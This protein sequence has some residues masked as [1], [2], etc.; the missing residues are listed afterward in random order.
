MSPKKFKFILWDFDGVI[1]DSNEIREYGFNQILKRYSTKQ[2]QDLISFH[3][4]NGGLSRYVKFRYFF[5][6]I[7]KKPISENEVNLLANQF[8]LIMRKRLVDT[9]LIIPETIKYIE[10]L[11]NLKKEMHIVSGSDNNELIELCSKI[12]VDKYFKTISGS[13]T[14]KNELVSRIITRNNLKLSDVC[15]IG[16]AVND[17]DAAKI[18]G[19]TFFGYNNT[20]L[21]NLDQ[22]LVLNNLNK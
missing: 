21:K 8:S 5:E 12:N 4:L 19:I 3:R 22:Y 17:F 18:N 9:S 1:I 16:D 14:A 2:K 20:K 6:E 13:P 15:L 11:F 7:L 10:E